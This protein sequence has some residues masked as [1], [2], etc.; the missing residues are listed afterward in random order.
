MARCQKDRL[1]TR[2]IRSVSR[3]TEIWAAPERDTE[4]LDK[5]IDDEAVQKTLRKSDKSIVA[6]KSRNGDLAKGLTET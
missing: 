4:F 5:S 1:G 2:E 3:E 6:K